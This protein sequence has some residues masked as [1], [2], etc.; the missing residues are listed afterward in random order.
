MGIGVTTK[1][2]YAS[3]I[4]ILILPI[5][6]VSVIGT[7]LAYGPYYNPTDFF[8]N[9]ISESGLVHSSLFSLPKFSILE[10]ACDISY[11]GENFFS[12]A[13]KPNIL[14]WMYTCQFLGDKAC[15][16]PLCC[17]DRM[18]DYG[19]CLNLVSVLDL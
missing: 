19:Y 7:G 1:S 17:V 5:N 9:C 8:Y 2:V 18:V 3:D 15:F 11:S 16:A 10:A 14:Y 12:C 6:L 4:S 13:C